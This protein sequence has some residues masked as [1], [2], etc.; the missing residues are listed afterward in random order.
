MPSAMTLS[1]LLFA[2]AT[3]AS[4]LVAIQ[5]EERDL[6][7]EH[8]TTYAEYRRHVP[9]L[10][11]LGRDARACRKRPL[12]ERRT[13]RPAWARASSGQVLGL[14]KRRTMLAFARLFGS[15]VASMFA[16]VDVA[17]TSR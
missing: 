17:G 4:I 3:T 14:E 10:L 6:L 2:L 15:S 1:H 16:G 8:G 9:M 5:F 11:P 13:I 12:R 7:N